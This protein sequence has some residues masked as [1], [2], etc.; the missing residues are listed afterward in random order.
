MTTPKFNDKPLVETVADAIATADVD[1][2][3]YE[4][5]AAAALDAYTDWSWRNRP[6]FTFYE[7]SAAIDPAAWQSLGRNNDQEDDGA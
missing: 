7:E 4:E 1:G 6:K 5:L 3:T 2:A